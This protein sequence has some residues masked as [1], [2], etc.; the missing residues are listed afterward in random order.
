MANEIVKNLHGH[1]TIKLTNVHTGEEKIIEDNNT[2]T[3]YL[4]KLLNSAWPTIHPLGFR[5]RGMFP[6]FTDSPV[7]F[8]KTLTQGV[9]CF[10]KTIDE[11]NEH[12][13]LL[14]G[15]ATCVACGTNANYTGEVTEYGSYNS[16]EYSFKD[17]GNEHYHEYV[18]DFATN[19]GNGKINSICLTTIAGGRV[20]GG[21]LNWNSDFYQTYSSTE[22]TFAIGKNEG[23][24]DREDS[25]LPYLPHPFNEGSLYGVKNDNVPGYSAF[26]PWYNLDNDEVIITNQT[27]ASN[28]TIGNTSCYC[29]KKGHSYYDSRANSWDN[30][31]SRYLYCNF[32]HTNESDYWS[33]I[34]RPLILW[35][36]HT[37]P[38]YWNIYS[39]YYKS[40]NTNAAFDEMFIEKKELKLPDNIIN[41]LKESYNNCRNQ[42][43][44]AYRPAGKY[45]YTTCYY[46]NRIFAS[47]NYLY[48]VFKPYTVSEA[49]MLQWNTTEHIYVWKI[50]T[51]FTDSNEHPYKPEV[52]EVVNTSGVSMYIAE[53]YIKDQ[54]SIF[55]TDNY[56]FCWDINGHMWMYDFSTEEW[57]QIYKKNGE[58]CDYTIIDGKRFFPQ[59]TWYDYKSNILFIAGSDVDSNDDNDDGIGGVLVIVKPLIQQAAYLNARG[60][61]M[62][63]TNYLQSFSHDMG[64]EV[65]GI[66]TH[67]KTS[68]KK[69]I[70][71]LARLTGANYASSDS[72]RHYCQ[73][74]ICSYNYSNPVLTTINNLPEEVEKTEDYT[75]K[76]TYRISWD[77]Q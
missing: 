12:N 48:Q 44:Q 60:D 55:V 39:S 74:F 29:I 51:D 68:N 9:I 65:Q 33:G 36:Y 1:T 22:S 54:T 27:I 23:M 41:E 17:S 69:M 52:I 16:A 61:H 70:F 76:I 46:A 24:T 13:Y 64:W 25:H 45:I 42:I 6:W 59:R 7:N 62:I 8:I 40:G 34:E 26:Y 75:M 67:L 49:G 15:N 63:R 66:Y 32:F 77:S 31:D 18:W 73:P 28:G 30:T 21:T 72:D 2:I 43:Y 56:L 5:A 3:N 35:K 58:P 57:K 14:P 10:D 19:Q 11:E 50:P 47:D 20:G 4:D 53:N 38:K 71:N 37:K